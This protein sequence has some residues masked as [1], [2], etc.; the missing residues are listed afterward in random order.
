M[1]SKVQLPHALN[2]GLVGLVISGEVERGIF[3]GKLHEAGAHLV[4]ICLGLGFNGHFDNRFG[5]FH[6]LQN[7]LMVRVAKSFTRDRF[8][9]THKTATNT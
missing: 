2:D 8:L 1:I 6:A 5:E 4:D 3:A 9:N 7:D